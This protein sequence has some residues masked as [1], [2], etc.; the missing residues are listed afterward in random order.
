MATLLVWAS[1]DGVWLVIIG[2]FLAS[3][4]TTEERVAIATSALAGLRVADVMAPDPP[5]AAAWSTVQDFTSLAA[6]HS[7]HSAFP[8]LGS[9]GQLA[10]VVTTA[11]LA[12]IRPEQQP[13]L[14]LDQV[15][16]S[17]PSRYLAAPGDPAGPLLTR[18]PLGGEVA[19]VVVEHGQVVGLVTGR[20][21]SQAVRRATQ[22][23]APRRGPGGRAPRAGRRAERP[24]PRCAL[25]FRLAPAVAK[26]P[27]ALAHGPW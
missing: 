17:V 18:S 15:A 7:R 26:V 9:G 12:R 13:V 1:L 3:A 2:W 23:S 21:L 6:T 14:R 20:D 8:V 11:Q 5:F 16:L 27:P 10:G 24:G 22:R 19:A 4:A 25:T